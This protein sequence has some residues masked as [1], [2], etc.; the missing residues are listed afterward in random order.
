[1]EKPMKILKSFLFVVVALGFA[2]SVFA[3]MEK[4][5]ITI[6]DLFKLKNVSSPQISP[7]GEWIAYVV[8][9]TDVKA[10]RSSS[11]IW[12]VS[13]DGK[14]TRQVTFTPD[15]GESNPRWSP[16]GKYLSFV[17]SRPGPNRGSQVW[18]I[19]LKGGEARQLTEVKGRLQS[20]EWAPDSKRMAMVI[21]DP[22]PEADTPEANRTPKPI[23]VDRYRFKQD[24][25]GYLRSDR[26]SYIYLY[27]IDSKRLDRLTKG[28]HDE[29]SPAW[30]PDGKRIAFTS[31]RA[32]DP[33]RAPFVRIYV[34]EAKPFS[35]EKQV[36]PDESRGS[37]GPR[38]SPD[39]KLIAYMETDENKYGAY[40][41][42]YLTVVASDG[43]ATPFR[44]SAVEGLDRGVSNHTWSADGKSILVFVTDDRSV[45]PIRVPVTGGK[46]ERLLNPP[47]VV[48]SWSDAKGRI[49]LLSTNNNAPNEIHVLENGRLRKLSSHND[50][51][52]A[53][54]EIA[55]TEQIDFTSADGTRVGA[56]I[57]Y[58]I[59][60]KKGTRVPLLLWIHG[61]PNAQ[62]QNSFA[63]TSQFFAANGYAVLAVNYRGS[64][65]RGQ[66]FSRAIAADWGNYEVQ[67]LLAGIDHVVKEGIADPDKLGVGGWSYGGILTNYIIASTDRF[68]A[69]ASGAGTAFTVSFYG[70]DQYIIQYDYE[71]GPPWKPEAWETYQ[72]LAYPLLKADRIK[73]PTLY[74][75]GERD[76]NVPISG[77]EQMYQA[78][79]SLGV[80][81]QLIVYPNEYHGISRPSFVR[82]RY[83]RYL[84]WFDKYVIKK[85]PEPRLMIAGWEGKWRGS[86]RDI[87][88]KKDAPQIEV[89]LE[90]G[91]IPT[92][93]NTCAMWKTS[94]LED[95]VVKQVKDYKFCRGTGIEDLFIDE[96]NGVKIPVKI[97]GDSLIAT[98]KT[99]GM[100]FVST[101]RLRGESLEQEILTIDDKVAGEGVSPL[102]AKGIQKLEV[103]RVPAQ[104]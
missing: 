28:K 32:P 33:D 20:Y 87:P 22:D 45:Y 8:S 78:L 59:G 93:D 4:R 69:G 15:Q 39:G 26:K 25:Q 38:W 88:A 84:G 43:S 79:K 24:V 82:D 100:A 74:L 50:E 11:D 68:K 95:A 12:L 56:M 85:T 99:A 91:K 2:T 1:M 13:Y 80:D 54:L 72:K 49:A 76:F 44:P 35:V 42:N 75:G 53:K 102:N 64:S 90:I 71:I 31:N 23:V 57:T 9:T 48:S 55:T 60:Y 34:A 77:S 94:F 3:Q 37:G 67:D 98:F 101:M 63:Q 6:D 10:D 51:I 58:P 46:I 14:V 18:V 30:S 7:D 19:D 47:V 81:T 41:M 66:K 73:T 16:D 70:V 52:L 40:D 21:G 89:E 104:Q 5:S 27:D 86:L 29:G 65:G 92:S 83:E 36:T 96:G 97:I 62:D 61:G 17:S 103:R